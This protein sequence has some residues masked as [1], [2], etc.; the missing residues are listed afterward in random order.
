M[1]K[2][3]L[4]LGIGL[5]LLTSTPTVQAQTEVELR[6]QYKTLLIQLISLLQ[7]QVR[8]LLAQQNQVVIPT[9]PI[10]MPPI[11]PTTPAVPNNQEAIPSIPQPIK[12]ECILY[13]KSNGDNPELHQYSS[14]KARLKFDEQSK[15][16]EW[17][18]E[19][20]RLIQVGKKNWWNTGYDCHTI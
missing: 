19:A 16:D 11:T 3:L 15:L 10:T 20:D 4:S 9:T 8:L 12:W 1:K 6:E 13:G 7:E 14:V 2:L 18:S 17:K 5:M